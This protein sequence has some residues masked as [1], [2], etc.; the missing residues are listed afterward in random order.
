MAMAT[1]FLPKPKNVY[2]FVT[3]QKSLLY[4]YFVIVAECDIMMV[5]PSQKGS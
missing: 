3:Q 1:V 2:L 4:D 5:E